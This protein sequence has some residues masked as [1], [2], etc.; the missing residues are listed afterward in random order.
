MTIHIPWVPESEPIEL[1]TMHLLV[2]NDPAVL[3]DVIQV[4]RQNPD[5]RVA[6]SRHASRGAAR[7][8]VTSLRQSRRFENFP[9]VVFETRSVH[10]GTPALGVYILMSTPNPVESV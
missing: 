6:W 10:P 5:R 3:P 1:D 9:D 2:E 8:R 7:Q 4:L